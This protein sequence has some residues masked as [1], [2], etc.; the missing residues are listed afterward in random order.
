MFT[1]YIEL[2]RLFAYRK[3]QSPAPIFSP[4]LYPLAGGFSV[5][6]Q[7][8]LL[9]TQS[10]KR[11]SASALPHVSGVVSPPKGIAS[12]KG[13]AVNN[14]FLYV[15]ICID[16]IFFNKLAARLHFF[17]H[18]RAKNPISL[19]RIGESYTH[20]FPAGRIHRCFPQ[21]RAVHFT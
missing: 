16:C 12:G 1:H 21:L 5:T 20:H 13:V 10:G 15:Q 11:I 4:L 2:G 3:N 14:S 17:P 19:Y 9:F 7:S 18:E 6:L 8:S